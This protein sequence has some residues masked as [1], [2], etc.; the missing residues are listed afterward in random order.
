MCTLITG[1]AP[2]AAKTADDVF[3]DE[4]GSGLCR[5]VVYHCYLSP[6]GEVIRGGNDVP[7]LGV[8]GDRGD[9]TYEINSPLFKRPQHMH[10]V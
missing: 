5:A 4:L 1:Q 2:W 8:S 10:W 6:P 7:G 9:G 3:K